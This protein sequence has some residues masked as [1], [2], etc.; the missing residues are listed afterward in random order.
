M[1]RTEFF[2]C[3][4][5]SPE[6]VLHFHFDPEEPAW[7][8]IHAFLAPDPFWQRI[9]NAVKYIFGYK[10]RYGHFDEFLL[11]REDCDKFMDLLQAYKATQ[12]AYPTD[13]DIDRLR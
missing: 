10:C 6:H 7:L 13:A 11:R 3:A 2:E 5:Y 8:L 1:S 4:C 12:Q 9:V